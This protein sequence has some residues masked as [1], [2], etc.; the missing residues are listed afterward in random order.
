MTATGTLPDSAP[1]RFVDDCPAAAM[2]RATLEHLTRPERL[3]QI[4]EAAG[5]RQSPKKLLFS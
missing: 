4:F 2:V 1:D 5:Q 3:D